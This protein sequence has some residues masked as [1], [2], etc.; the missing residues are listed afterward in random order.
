MCV[1]IV[2]FSVGGPTRVCNPNGATGVLASSKVF[3]FRHLTPGLVHHQV[4]VVRNQRHA[5]TVIAPVFQT[6]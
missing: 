4:I 1:H 2:G 5:G 3:Q 6:L